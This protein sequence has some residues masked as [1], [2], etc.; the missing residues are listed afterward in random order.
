[1]G[2]ASP[3]VDLTIEVTMGATN[4]AASSAGKNA[5]VQVNPQS[6]ILLCLW[7]VLQ[8]EEHSAHVCVARFVFQYLS[9]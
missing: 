4:V 1:M 8:N 3:Q 5:A 6:N 2:V 7:Q 9:L